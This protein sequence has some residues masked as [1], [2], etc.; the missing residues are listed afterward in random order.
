[1]KTRFFFT[2]ST[3]PGQFRAQ[4][5]TDITKP[6]RRAASMAVS[7][8]HVALLNLHLDFFPT[9]PARNQLNDGVDF[10]HTF[11]VVKLQHDR[12]ADAAVNARMSR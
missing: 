4:E 1:M 10:P 7:A 12:V 6:F 11:S 9:P 3:T 8:T 5:R 2:A